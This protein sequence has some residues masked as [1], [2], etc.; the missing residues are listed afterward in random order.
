MVPVE[1]R[2]AEKLKDQMHGALL[3]SLRA[4]VEAAG[5]GT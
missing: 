5:N 4:A 3:P 2:I 1:Q